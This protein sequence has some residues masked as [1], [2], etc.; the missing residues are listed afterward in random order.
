MLNSR[1]KTQKKSSWSAIFDFP[2]GIDSA[3]NVITRSTIRS[4]SKSLFI[5]RGLEKMAV[6]KTT[7]SKP[8]AAATKKKAKAAPKK[9]APAK[10]KKA[11]PKK[12]SASMAMKKAS[13][14]KAATKK[15]A[16]V[17]LS[18]PQTELLKKIMGAGTMGYCA[19]KAEVRTI[20]ALVGRK[21]VKHGMKSATAKGMYHYTVSKMGAKLA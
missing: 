9:K 20:E 1:V 11:A 15:A 8:A 2:T 16:P 3:K 19:D 13:P 5:V 18:P 14:K 6:K 4:R 10:K 7:T 12:A 21:L 17:K